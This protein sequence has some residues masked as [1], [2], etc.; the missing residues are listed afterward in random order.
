M[1]E[2]AYYESPIGPLEVVGSKKEIFSVRFA[3]C[4]KS[5]AV[6]RS[7]AVQKCVEQ[8]DEYFNGNRREFSL[9]LSLSGTDFDKRVWQEVLRIPYGQTA[10]YKDIA[11]AIG[12]EKASRAVGGANGRNRIAIIIP[13]HRVVA[14]DGGW[15]GYGGG[16]WR[17]KWLLQHEKRSCGQRP[18]ASSRSK[19]CP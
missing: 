3:S 11:R 19:D 1:E 15:G 8:L 10:S 4:P 18:R 17:K 16:L 9:R 7:P 6:L 12:N 13:C 2:K 5:S 14:Q